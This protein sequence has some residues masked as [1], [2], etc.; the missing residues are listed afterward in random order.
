MPQD[1]NNAPYAKVLTFAELFDENRLFKIPNYQRAYAWEFSEV[2]DLL[3]D[4]D[5][6]AIMREQDPAILHVMGMITCQFSSNKERPLRVVDGQQRL[7]T[8]ALIHANLS[9]RVQK[10]SFLFTENDNVRL[11]PQAIDENY[12]YK[13]LRGKTGVGKTRGQRNYATAAKTI[14]QWIEKNK[15]TP[16]ELRT[17]VEDG[18]SLILFTL[19]NEADVARVFE[20]INNRGRNVT[21]LD[22]VKNHLIHLVHVKDWQIN[23][24]EVWSKIATTL[25]ILDIDDD[26]ADR[27][28]RAVVTAQFHPG[29]RNA[30]ETDAKIIAKKLPV[31]GES[32]KNERENFETFL[33]FIEKAFDT[34][35]AL[36]K[37][38]GTSTKRMKALTYLRHHG[39]LTSVLPIILTHEYL[40]SFN[41][42]PDDAT[43][44]EVIEKV[45]FRLYGLPKASARVDSHEVK[46]A[47]AAHNYFTQEITP[48]E[49][50]NELINVVKNK[51]Q[52]PME[53]IVK[54][55]TL[56]DN[57][58][59][60]FSKQGWRKWL[61]YFLARWEESLL[62]N[63]SFDFDKLR[64]RGG[65]SN[66]KLEVEHIWAQKHADQTLKDYKKGLLIRRLGNLMLMPK[67]MNVMLS[68]H[69]PEIKA[70][71]MKQLKI[72][73]LQQNEDLQDYVQAAVGFAT[74]L[75]TKKAAA[76]GDNTKIQPRI[77]KRCRNIVMTKI[78]CDLREENMIRF[79]L[80]AWKLDG[81]KMDGFLGVHSF[82][83]AGSSYRHDIEK[84]KT[85]A[86][87]NYLLSGKA[88]DALERRHKARIELFRTSSA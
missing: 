3:R 57:E 82:A 41:D 8:L 32:S 48:E 4:I 9:R 6:L 67:G 26:E 18:L 69:L 81:E 43:V 51:Q 24:Q 40:H 77:I 13:V 87:Q 59:F 64:G 56:D 36:L 10:S 20:A 37:S 80:D 78:L 11:K 19:R 54:A 74:Y 46:F 15:R 62:Q 50:K 86:E 39:T 16:E 12:F 60:N 38:N 84:N 53:S 66:D 1:I 58:D 61:R 35:R 75:E 22:L 34:Y 47:K 21:Q 28:L 42:G 23:V 29:K 83:H 72:N 63:Q 49:L 73:K 70:G 30:G 44:L 45:N 71:K 31:F 79:A 7:T 65:K 5:R 76:F 88:S 17:L 2:N 85:K 27:V 33:S 52:T 14:K 25:A 55:L 68:N